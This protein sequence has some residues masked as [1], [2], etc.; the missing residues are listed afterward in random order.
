MKNIR[1]IKSNK[2]K[3]N[4]LSFC[5]L[6]M[7]QAWIILYLYHQKH[8]SS[9]RIYKRTAFNL[10]AKH[11][12][13][14]CVSFRYKSLNQFEQKNIQINILLFQKWSKK[15]SRIPISQHSFWPMVMILWFSDFSIL[16][17]LSIKFNSNSIRN[18]II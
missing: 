5:F 11:S 9:L 10:K 3:T 4:D 18:I 16:N 12:L 8:S 17:F 14:V 2:Q 6:K 13:F 1:I 7:R 15:G